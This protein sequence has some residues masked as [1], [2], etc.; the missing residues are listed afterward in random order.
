MDRSNFSVLA[1]Q[2]AEIWLNKASVKRAKTRRRSKVLATL[3]CASL[4]SS[5]LLCVVQ[6]EIKYTLTELRCSRSLG[7]SPVAIN[8]GGE[9]AGWYFWGDSSYHA[10]IYRG[11]ATH[12]LGSL[13]GYDNIVTSINNYGQVVGFF[14]NRYN[15]NSFIEFAYL[16]GSDGSV[17]LLGSLGN[18]AFTH[19]SGISDSGVIVGSSGSTDSNTKAFIYQNGQMSA[20]GTFAGRPLKYASINSRG[21]I[22]ATYQAADSSLKSVLISGGQMQDLSSLNGTSSTYAFTISDNGIILG[23]YDKG[24]FTYSAG[25]F[26]DLGLNGS[27][28]LRAINNNGQVVGW[29]INNTGGRDFALLSNGVQVQDL[30]T[31]IDPSAGVYLLYAWDISNSGQIGV[32]GVNPSGRGV[33]YLLTPIK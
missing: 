2:Q 31:L 26:H 15:S 27:A 5:L 12:D 13:S 17:T 20:L 24:Y 30:N 7:S 21:Q 25:K 6:A 28:T 19:P 22:L 18:A 10:F 16:H 33:A 11:G 3:F 4:V 8:N 32:Y 1:R 9:V 29:N 14:Q 23:S